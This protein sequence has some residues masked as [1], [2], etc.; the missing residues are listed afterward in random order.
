MGKYRKTGHTFRHDNM[1]EYHTWK[2]MHDRCTRKNDRCYYLYGGR[3]IKVCS[4]WRNFKNFL[5]DMGKRPNGFV[6]DRIDNSKGYSKKNCRWVSK[7]ESARNKRHIVNYKYNGVLLNLNQIAKL[8][9]TK[10]CTL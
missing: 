6:I 3:G 1:S 10:H 5:I 8:M 7:L 9:G 2:S 4:S